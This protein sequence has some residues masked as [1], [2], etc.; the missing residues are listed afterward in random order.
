MSFTHPGEWSGRK[1]EY[2]HNIQM[3]TNGLAPAYDFNGVQEDRDPRWFDVW[4]WSKRALI[5]SALAMVIVIVII[6]AVAVVKVKKNAYSDYSQLNYTLVDH[7]MAPLAS[8]TASTNTG[9]CFWD[10]ILR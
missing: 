3:A 7:C 6:I 2:D 10:F 8:V 9:S 4:Y 5:L 1:S